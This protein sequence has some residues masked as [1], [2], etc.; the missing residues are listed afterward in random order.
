MK[1][2]LTKILALL[3]SL[4]IT[5][6]GCSFIKP[7][8]A[9]ID[10][11]D[12]TAFGDMVYSRPDLASMEAAVAE[13]EALARD[14]SDLE[15][16]ASKIMEVN[17]LYSSFSTNYYLATIH[18][19]LDLSDQ[20]WA[21]E[22]DHCASLSADVQ[23]TMDQLLYA[24]ADSPLREEL[25][26]DDY[27][28]EG[29]FDAYDGSS[30]W[31]EEFTAL[32]DQE[33]E[34]QSQYYDALGAGD[35]ALIEMIFMDM[36]ILRQN[37]ALEAGYLDYPS[38]AYDFYYS[39]D[40]TPQ[41]IQTYLKDIKTDLV[42]LYQN[43]LLRGGWQDESFSVTTTQTQ[44]YVAQTAAA[45]GGT[46][47]KAYEVMEEYDLFHIGYGDNKLNASFEVFLPDYML[48][49]VFVSPS[50]TN[51]DQL[52]FTHEFGHFCNDFASGGTTASV[53]VAEIF[54]QGLEYLSLLYAPNGMNNTTAKMADSLC[55]YVEQA[56]YASFELQLYALARDEISAGNI[57]NIF[58]QTC[59]EFG[60]WEQFFEYLSY[61]YINH[62]FTSPLYV[63]SYVLSNDAAMQIYQMELERSGAGLACYEDN[64]D[65]TQVQLLAFLESAGLESPFT[66]GR[67]AQVRRI[68][69]AEL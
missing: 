38:F 60:F 58:R 33:A 53:D 41:Q 55:V 57:E 49:F 20:Q 25:E 16:L 21:G 14:G 30:I 69:E 1:L 39:R 26:G 8:I 3:L 43:L 4:S 40:Y 24:L 7:N 66:P 59:R 44:N 68:L 65:T 61:T 47:S 12:Y 46:I 48:P 15:A 51:R 54:S 9:V 10:T 27:F 28:G 63:I 18:Y 5:L 22:Y 34:L 17:A 2:Q 11:P 67:T 56:A 45:M 29:F 32:M 37:I 64:L 13:C 50:G 6:C 52:S 36:I 62:F 31:T 42:P 35:D 19:N 23:A